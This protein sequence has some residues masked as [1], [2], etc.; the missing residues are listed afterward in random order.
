MMHLSWNC[1]GLENP[2]T[3]QHLREIT[4]SHKPVMVFLSETHQHSHYVNNVRKKLGYYKCSNVDPIKTAGGLSLWW[5]PDV[6][7]EIHDSTNF[8]ID[9]TVSFVKSCTKARITWVYGPP[10]YSDKATFWSSW[11]NKKRGDGI[12]WLVIGD[13]N[14]MLWQHE[15]EGG[16]PWSLNRNIFLKAFLDSN[17]LFDIGFKGQQFT[18]AKKEFGEVVIQE[19]LDRGLINDDWLLAW[20]DSCVTHLTRLGSDHCPILFE[21]CPAL[22]KRRPTFKFEA[23]WVDDAE[24][25]PL[26]EANWRNTSHSS[27]QQLWKKNLSTCRNQLA[28]WSNRRFTQNRLEIVHSL[29]ELDHLQCHRPDTS[30]F[31]QSAISSRLN[32]LWEIEEKKWHQRSRINWLQAG[33][34]NTRFFHLTTLH[35]RQT[36]RI[37]KIANEDGYWIVGEK[38]IRQAFETE[39]KKIY[40]SMG[41][42]DWGGLIMWGSTSGY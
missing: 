22:E 3:V 36:N 39:F 31:E 2:L 28:K 32:S 30:S 11:S 13:L 5:K 38:L 7:V 33:D 8:F 42:R 23:Y 9:T 10:Y 12:P 24:C 18:W 29:K 14:E 27:N 34:A 6:S 19:R 26:I 40:T 21:H 15:M 35:R 37:L 41:P 4:Q 20:P 16:V 25:F 17:N 1:Q